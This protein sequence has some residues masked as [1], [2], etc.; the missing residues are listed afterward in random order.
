MLV[1]CPEEITVGVK[2]LEV[3]DPVTLMLPFMLR[4]PL[5]AFPVKGAKL[6]RL[7]GA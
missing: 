7:A 3:S 6:P 4:F 1:N 2:V 5:T